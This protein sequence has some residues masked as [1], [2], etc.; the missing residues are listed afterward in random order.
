M[1]GSVDVVL[2]TKDSERVLT[3]CVESIYQNVPV[4]QLIVVDGYSTDRT[5]DILNN[6]N[7]R[8]HNVKILFDHGTRATARQKGID[9]VTAEWFMF[10]DSDVVLCPDWFKKAQKYIQDD[11]AAIWGIEVWSTITNP[12]T[13]KMFLI[14]TRKIFEVRG[15]THDTLIRTSLIKDIKIPDG[16]HVFE[17]A[18]IKDWLT[19]KGY[20]VVACYSPFCIHYRSPEV[21]TLSGS[22]GLIAEAFKFGS[23]QLITRL[24]LAY[25]FYAAYSISQLF[26]H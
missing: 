2:L 25:G 12:K 21:W 18:Y 24:L 6:F 20:K 9:N 26:S 16:L 22:L 17:D 3:E 8:Y 13:L 4:A 7:D 1:D 10:V 14:T 23:P 11:V 15:G 19:D 5:I